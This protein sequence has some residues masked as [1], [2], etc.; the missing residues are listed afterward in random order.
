MNL[1]CDCSCL[2]Q[3]GKVDSRMG[4]GSWITVAWLAARTVLLTVG[5][6]VQALIC[7]DLGRIPV[8]KNGLA[9]AV[10]RHLRNME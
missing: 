7:G 9:G 2:M 3:S 1:T 4:F 6:V 8:E 10:Y 5:G